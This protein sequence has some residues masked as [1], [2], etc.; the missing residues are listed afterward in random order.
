SSA[1]YDISSGDFKIT[2]PKETPG[3]FFEDLDLLSKLLARKSDLVPNSSVGASKGL[4][5]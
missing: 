5:E 3:E 4:I 2:L 1:K